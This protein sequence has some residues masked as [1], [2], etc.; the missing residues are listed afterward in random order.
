MEAKNIINVALIQ[1]QQVQ[2][3]I[4]QNIAHLRLI[5]EHTALDE[6]D[7]LLL[8]EMWT[9]GFVTKMETGISDA[10]DRGLNIMKE[11]S[12]NYGCAVYGSLLKVLDGGKLA[13]AG[14]F[15]DVSEGVQEE[16]HKVH[17]F[18]PGGE[19]KFFEAG[20][21][22]CMVSWRGWNIFLTICYDLRFPV[23]MRYSDEIPYD[24]ILCTANWP[25]PRQEAWKAL[26][27][28]RAID[29]QAYV[30]GCNRVGQGPKTLLYPGDSVIAGPKGDLLHEIIR[31]EECVIKVSLDRCEV[32]GFRNSFPVL[33]DADIF[34]LL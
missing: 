34:K 28:A 3:D 25:Y 7:L 1:M 27:R 13:N 5:L 18:G 14:V 19:A 15:L 33:Q 17:L 16:Y 22:R 12:K 26:L 10:Y 8:P 2:C 4:D 30:L 29:N 31:D 11:L 20:N 21:K 24:M 9:T 23:W 32:K 6:I